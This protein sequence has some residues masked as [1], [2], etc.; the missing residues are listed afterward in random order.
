MDPS[1]EEGTGASGAA[2]SSAP[3]KPDRKM[4]VVAVGFALALFGL[5]A[6]NMN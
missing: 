5:I 2:D 1:N 3:R 6:L 4:L